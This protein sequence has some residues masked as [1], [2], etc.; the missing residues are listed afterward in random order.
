[1][2]YILDLAKKSK[3]AKVSVANSDTKTRNRVLGAIYD[4]LA[5]NA[6]AIMAANAVDIEEARRTGK[7]E[8]FIDRLT[9]NE[10]RIEGMRQSVD[11]I[12]RMNDP[13]GMILEGFTRPNGL[14]I[15]KVT[16]PIG[17]IGIIFESRPNVSVD[18]AAL[19]LK[20]GNAVVLR[21]G[22]DS[23]NSNKALVDI[24]RRSAAD[25]GLNADCVQLVEDTSRETAT[26]MMK[27]NGYI[28]LLIP[29]G[30]A[31]LINH[32]INN[33]SLPVIETG[34]GNCHIYVDKDAQ[35]DMAVSITDNA[36]TNRPSVCNAAETLLV[37]ADVAGEFL[38]AA[39]QA[40]DRSGVVLF[41]CPKTADILGDCVKEA[42]DQEYATEYNDMKL[43]VRVV[44]SIDHAIEH[45]RQ[46]STEHSEAIVTS[47]IAAA[48][49]FLAE[50][51][52]AAV[53]VNASTR[54][55]DGGEFGYGGEIGIS[56][57]KLH[58]RGPMGIRELT[59]IKYKI[60]GNGQVR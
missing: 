14:R 49:K 53:Y 48:E 12:R 3:V 54:F 27:L 18:A 42:N 40:L 23:I 5:Q 15:E 28:D 45:I 22:S 11:E 16:V 47:N 44:D 30:G 19:C 20:S 2:S 8:A 56:T 37:H 31:G 55:T 50:I 17:V 29:R 7:T 10:Q 6:E 41:G 24:M 33:S 26:E 35:I 43:A 13:L 34:A 51:D 39:K 58:A 59:T 4:A 52:S 36:K 60:Y 46:Y 21:G 38:P 57:G 25:E 1:M 32:V 9:L